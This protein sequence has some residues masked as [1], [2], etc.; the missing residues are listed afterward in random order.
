[1][2]LESLTEQFDIF[3]D[4]VDEI[5]ARLEGLIESVEDRIRSMDEMED[6]ANLELPF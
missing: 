3:A 4:T 6:P 2:A 1:M 5:E